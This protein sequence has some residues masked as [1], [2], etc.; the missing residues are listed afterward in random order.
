MV[1]GGGECG[2][3]V[4]VPLV[5]ATRL[6]TCLIVLA[7]KYRGKFYSLDTFDLL[8]LSRAFKA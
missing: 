7:Q 4:K 6:A 1:W 8:Q 5:F 3:S 2:M